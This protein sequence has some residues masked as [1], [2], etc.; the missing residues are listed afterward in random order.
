MRKLAGCPV[1]HEALGTLRTELQLCWEGGGGD[2]SS[3]HHG[4]PTMPLLT[5]VMAWSRGHVDR[6]PQK[7]FFS[8]DS[9]SVLPNCPKQ[10][11]SS[12]LMP[13]ISMELT[14]LSLCFFP[15]VS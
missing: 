7:P 12:P 10:E 15:T 3:A 4:G 9:V 14:S 1:F 11:D 5:E 8:A 13:L 2:S 6:L